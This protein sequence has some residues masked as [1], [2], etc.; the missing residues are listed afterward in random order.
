MRTGKPPLPTR[1]NARAPTGACGLARDWSC[2]LRLAFTLIELLIVIAIIAILAALLMPALHKAQQEGSR[3][4]C[5][6]NLRQLALAEQMYGADNEGKLADNNPGSTNDWVNGNLVRLQDATNQVPLRAGKL[7]PYASDPGVYHCPADRSQT[8]GLPRV[9]SYSMN[10][11]V[12]SHYMESYPAQREFKTFL[13][14]SQLASVGPASIFLIIDEHEATI[15]DAW[16]LVTMDDS[17]PFASA[18]ATRHEMGYALNFADGHAELF[19]LMDPRSARLG[20]EGAQF[21][22][23]NLDWQRLKSVTTVR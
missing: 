19:R 13:R 11:W 12:G 18:P 14:D 3:V 10:G 1:S 2:S 22:R 8:N 7:F 16:F 6:G 21:A 15:N 23:D 4:T 5:E 20:S 17:R 9:R